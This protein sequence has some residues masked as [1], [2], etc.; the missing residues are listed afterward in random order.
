M[1]KSNTKTTK[2]QTKGVVTQR[3]VAARTAARKAPAVTPMR[4]REAPNKDLLPKGFDAWLLKAASAKEG[5][6]RT[7]L[8]AKTGQQCKWMPYIR[9][10]AAAHGMVAQMWTTGRNN[11]FTMSKKG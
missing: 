7:V 8:T 3:K 5:V 9:E 6:M 11:S 10:L 2:A 4:W 1:A